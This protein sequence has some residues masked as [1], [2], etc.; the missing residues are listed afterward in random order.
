MGLFQVEAGLSVAATSHR[1]R[2]STHSSAGPPGPAIGNMERH[3]VTEEGA[4]WIGLL[5]LDDGGSVVG[6]GAP[7]PLGYEKTRVLIRIHGAP[8]GNVSVPAL[9]AETLT[10]RI[11]AAAEMTLAGALRRHD[12]C[13]HS[14]GQP[15]NGRAW[16]AQAGCPR[17]FPAC[18][19][20]GMTIV[21]CTRDRAEVLRECL[22][23]LQQVTYDPIEI[24]V[25]DNAPSGTTTR[26]V[27][28]SL[29]K[30]TLAF[31]TPAS[32]MPPV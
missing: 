20:P 2:A 32:R 15:G 28:T 13:D 21:I 31:D 7:V 17:Y 22:H 25:V 5:D 18:S 26:K 14:T 24:I 30:K 11:R 23:S 9:P 27:V 1:H 12:Y 10:A 16:A 29:A 19:G 3:V 4:V 6:L 8:L